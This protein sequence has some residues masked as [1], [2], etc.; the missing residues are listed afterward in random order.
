[1][2][3]T[4]KYKFA[5]R[6]KFDIKLYSS[7]TFLKGEGPERGMLY[8]NFE[9]EVDDPY[10]VFLTKYFKDR[11]SWL[12]YIEVINGG[13]GAHIETPN[14]S[15]TIRAI[16][17]V[18]LYE[19]KYLDN[20]YMWM[21][22]NYHTNVTLYHNIEPALMRLHKVGE[23]N[24]NEYEIFKRGTVSITNE[25]LHLS[26]LVIATAFAVYKMELKQVSYKNTAAE[27]IKDLSSSLH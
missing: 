19:F 13:H 22:E 2:Y 10:H 17:H 26:S 14:G 27:N 8:C 24:L 16:E 4:G 11:S 23:F 21:G 9:N 12:Y 3:P 20:L 25:Y 18:R 5:V 1:M 7:K 6:F 15:I